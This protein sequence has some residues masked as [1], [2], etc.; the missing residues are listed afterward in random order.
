MDAITKKFILPPMPV[1]AKK[2]H[3]YPWEETELMVLCQRLFLFAAK[4]GYT[5]TLEESKFGSFLENNNIIDGDDFE[6]YYGQYDVIPM[7]LVEQ[8]L[9]TKGKICTDDISIASI[10]YATTTNVAGGYT[11]IIG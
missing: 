3:I 1:A 11:A 10:P 4:T 9:Q 8:I 2:K 5:G 7:P 6:I